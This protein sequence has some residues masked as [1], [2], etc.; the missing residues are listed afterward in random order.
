MKTIFDKVDPQYLDH[1]AHGVECV[2]GTCG[3]V[4]HQYN[5]VTIAVIGIILLNAVILVY[6]TKEFSP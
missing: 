1:A 3:H 6:K 5:M 2:T 4:Q